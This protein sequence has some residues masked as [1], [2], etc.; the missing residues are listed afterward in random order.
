MDEL[1]L[2]LQ[3]RLEAL[4]DAVPVPPGAVAI[5][6]R[7]AGNGSSTRGRGWSAGL[8][9]YALIGLL[10]LVVS[11]TAMLLLGGQISGILNTVGAPI[12]EPSPDSWIRPEQGGHIIDLPVLRLHE[13]ASPAVVGILVLSGRSR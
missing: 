2:Q 9:T 5:P 1:D 6:G 10:L 7:R 11:V 8:T 4:S 3:R 13:P 12:G